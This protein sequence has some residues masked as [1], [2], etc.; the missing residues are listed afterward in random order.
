[1]EKKL[2]RKRLIY[3]RHQSRLLEKSLKLSEIQGEL[4]VESYS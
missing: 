2:D 1:M 4:E 3:Q